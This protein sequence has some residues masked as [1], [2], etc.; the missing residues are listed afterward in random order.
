ME[1]FDKIQESVK[2]IKGRWNGNPKVGIILGTGLGGFAQEIKQEASIPYKDI[3]HFPESTAP[4]HTGRMICGSIAGKQVV[5]MEGRF[6]F[7][8]GY[9]MEQITMPVR[10]LKA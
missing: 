7:Y 5:A 1:L 10:A 8:E 9:T 2:A 3:P 6:H 4:T